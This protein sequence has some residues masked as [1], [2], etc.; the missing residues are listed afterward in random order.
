VVGRAR[1]IDAARVARARS[2]DAIDG[3]ATVV[4][5]DGS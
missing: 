1:P 3:C 2:I 4:F 5:V